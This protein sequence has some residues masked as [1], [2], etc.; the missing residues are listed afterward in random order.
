VTSE[1]TSNTIRVTQRDP[2]GTPVSGSAIAAAN[3]YANYLNGGTGAAHVGLGAGQVGPQMAL[4]EKSGLGALLFGKAKIVAAGVC[5]PYTTAYA[6]AVAAN[7][8]FTQ[9]IQAKKIEYFSAIL[10]SGIYF[11]YGNIYTSGLP[12]R[13]NESAFNPA[14]KDAEQFGQVVGAIHNHPISGIASPSG[15]DMNVYDLKGSYYKGLYSADSGY[16]F[17]GYVG[18][19]AG[20]VGTYAAGSFNPGTL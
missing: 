8:V 18:N 13:V 16:Q 7:K 12:K 5:C 10:K 1:T 9:L 2:A 20:E 14:F 3:G 4:S 19:A 15:G 17:N 11:G 6:A